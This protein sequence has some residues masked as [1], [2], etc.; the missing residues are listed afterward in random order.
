M[1]SLLAGRKLHV[2]INAEVKTMKLFYL[3]ILGLLPPKH[4]SISGCTTLV[5]E[6]YF[7]NIYFL[8]LKENEILLSL[9][10]NVKYLNV[11]WTQQIN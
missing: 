11:Q 8:Y 5:L 4:S 1:Q 3:L 10:E 9:T 2:A 7:C 6:H